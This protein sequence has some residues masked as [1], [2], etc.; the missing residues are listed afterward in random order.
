MLLTVHK[1]LSLDLLYEHC[2]NETHL[3]IVLDGAEAVENNECSGRHDIDTLA[4][5]SPL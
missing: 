1:V 4:E 3:T 5:R 2:S